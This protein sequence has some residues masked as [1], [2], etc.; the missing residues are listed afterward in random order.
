[1]LSLGISIILQTIS[2][3]V[4]VINSLIGLKALRIE[5]KQA[6]EI[7]NQIND[8]NNDNISI[9]IADFE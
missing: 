7:S 4:L 3:V 1:M 8:C 5:N 9:T 6:L 2:S